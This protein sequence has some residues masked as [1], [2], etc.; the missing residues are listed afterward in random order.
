MIQE[1][2]DFKT[3][4]PADILERLNAHELKLSEKRD[5]YSSTPKVRALKSRAQRVSSDE[6]SEADTDN[7]ETLSRELALLTRKF[8]RFTKKNRF[9]NSSRSSSRK[10][11]DDDS[12]EARKRVCHKC[13]KPGHYIAECP[14]WEKE[15][16]LK[17]KKKG[18]DDSS[19]EKTKKKSSRSS[20]PAGY[21]N[22][23]SPKARAYLRKELDS[24]ESGSD[25][26]AEEE[27]EES[28]GVAGLA[29]A[30]SL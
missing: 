26:D 19:D 29:L 22:S 2:P 9:R 23:N 25:P 6:E 16:R 24:E 7:P 20:K 4:D 12:V 15:A 27:T 30:T 5:F 17:K 1:R 8:Q 21:R 28:E 13:K 18:K 11:K 10:S 3:L 14:L